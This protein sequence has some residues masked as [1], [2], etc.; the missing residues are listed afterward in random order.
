MDQLTPIF[1]EGSVA[2]RNGGRADGEFVD[3]DTVLARAATFL[4]PPQLEAVRAEADLRRSV[5]LLI[6]FYTKRGYKY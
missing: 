3:W 5:R 6:E 1:A 4:P 2:F